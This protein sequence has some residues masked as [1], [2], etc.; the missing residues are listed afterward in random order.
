MPG[1]TLTT[2]SC[3]LHAT[4]S[5]T[6]SPSCLFVHWCAVCTV[7][8]LAVCCFCCNSFRWRWKIHRQKYG[9][10]AFPRSSRTI[11]VIFRRPI[12]CHCSFLFCLS[13]WQ[14][15]GAVVWHRG[16]AA[17]Q[18]E[19]SSHGCRRAKGSNLGHSRVLHELSVAGALEAFSKKSTRAEKKAEKQTTEECN[20]TKLK[21][22]VKY[23]SAAVRNKEQ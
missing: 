10:T 12:K 7:A 18:D 8:A 21:N 11:V 2:T 1:R 14:D 22:K 23:Y 19:C 4:F 20:K 3:S 5:G 13:Q 15:G 9:A 17:R 16:K 6:H